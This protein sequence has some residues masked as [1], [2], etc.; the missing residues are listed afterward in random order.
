MKGAIGN[1]LIMNIVIT[2][3]VIFFSLLIGSMAFSKAYKVKKY[4]INQI[5]LY[6]KRGIMTFDSSDITN[7]NYIRWNDETN[8]FLRKMGYHLATSNGG[9]ERNEEEKKEQWIYSKEGQYD[10]CIFRKAQIYPSDENPTI[11]SKHYYK[12]RVYMKLDLPVIGD[13]IKL[14]ITGETKSYTKYR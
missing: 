6:E 3:I 5:D 10:Y 7:P 8:E 11:E 4:L 2:F 12:V 13:A 1:A 14:P 9:C